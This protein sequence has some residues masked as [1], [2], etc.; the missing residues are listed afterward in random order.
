MPNFND[1][2]DEDTG[3]GVRLVGAIVLFAII[4]FMGLAA[5]AIHAWVQT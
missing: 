3:D 4:V 2:A 1:P 5:W